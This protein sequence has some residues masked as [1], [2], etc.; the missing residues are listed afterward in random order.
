MAF[1]SDTRAPPT[2]HGAKFEASQVED[3]KSNDV[4]L[5][6]SPSRFSTGTLQSLRIRGQVEEPRM[7]ILCSS[8][9]TENP[10]KAFHQKCAERFAVH[11]PEPGEQ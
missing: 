5:P 6:S 8:A 9:P 3:I 2:Q 4:A 11:L 1:S 10:G 7:P